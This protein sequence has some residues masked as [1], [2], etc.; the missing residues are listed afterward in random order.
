MSEMTKEYYPNSNLYTENWRNEN[1]KLHRV[2]GP[3][4]IHYKNGNITIKEWFINGMAHRAYGPSDIFYNENGSIDFTNFYY[5]S[6]DYVEEVYK[7]IED[8]DFNSWEEMSESD[9]DRMW[10]EII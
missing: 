5:N 1:N 3:A 10:M 7:W 8:N 2:D 4:R 6:Y 9:F